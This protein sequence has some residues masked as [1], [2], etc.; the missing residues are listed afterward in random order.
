M[1]QPHRAANSIL[2]VSLL[3]VL[4]LANVAAGQKS[5][6]R[7][8][9]STQP[10]K[11]SERL[12][13]APSV[14]A[15]TSLL[16]LPP[17]YV[18]DN[19]GS[20][21]QRLAGLGSKLRKS[22][23]ETTADYYLRVK[24]LLGAMRIGPDRTA[25]DRLCFVHPYGSE[26]YD[27]DTQVFT[28]KPDLNY[29]GALGYDLPKIPRDVGYGF[30]GYRSIDITRTARNAGSRVGRTAFGI[31]K[32]I[33]VRAYAALRLVMSGDSVADW[34]I[35]LKF[36]VAPPMARE[37]SGRVW[38]AVTGRLMYPYF[39]QESDVDNATLDDPEEAHSF[40]YYLFF[41]PDSLVLYNISTGQIYGSWDLTESPSSI[42][43]IAN[44]TVGA[45]DQNSRTPSESGLFRRPRILSKPEPLYTEEARQNQIT[46]TV[47]LSVLLTETG[48]VT[49]IRVVRGLS[50]GLSERAIEAAKQ[51]KFVPAESNG[52][53]TSYKLI[54]EYNFNLY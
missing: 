49:E 17:K 41:V 21:Y 40:N 14:V 48:E 12:P 8:R 6:R 35:E 15:D 25:N 45:R 22:Q 53:K 52:K 16:Q 43:R 18:G 3:L 4:L 26:T 2:V 23:F 50:H 51:I 32:K 38:L 31:R 54:L 30:A 13:S 46:G 19:A 36:R 5:K 29:E 11:S 7:G 1:T 10:A 9:A 20:L 42:D 37:S 33:T 44:P 28:L 34:P 24:L 27:A 47:V 39:L